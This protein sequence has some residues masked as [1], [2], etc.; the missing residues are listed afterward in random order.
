MHFNK[1]TNIFLNLLMVICFLT[2]WYFFAPGSLGGRVEYVI[3]NGNSMEPDYHRGDLVIIAQ[4]SSYQVGDVVTYRD[5]QIDAYVIHRIIGED[6]GKYILKGDN[7]GWIDNTRPDR[8]QILGKQWLYIPK[9][10]EQIFWLRKPLNMALVTLVLGGGIIFSMVIQSDREKPTLKKKRKRNS[11]AGIL[12]YVLYGLS[13]FVFLFLVLTVFSFTKPVMKKAAPI[14]Y[15]QTGVFS[16]TANGSPTVYDDGQVETGEPVY[17]KSACVVNFQ[18]SYS[19]NGPDLEFITGTN[20]ISAI[21]QNDKTGWKKTLELSPRNS[22]NAVGYVNNASLDLCNLISTIRGIEEETGVRTSIYSVSIQSEIVIDGRMSGVLFRDMYTQNMNFKLDDVQFYLSGNSSDSKPS[23]LAREK[24]IENPEWVENQVN[25]LG[26]EVSVKLIRTIS[27]F[28]MLLSVFSMVVLWL[29]I[30]HISKVDR[31][32]YIRLKYGQMII[33]TA[34]SGWDKSLL[35]VDVVNIDELAKIANRHN[36]MI[37]HTFRDFKHFYL[38][39]NEG[40]VYRYFYAD[41][42]Y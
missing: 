40:T 12:E 8:S 10:G 24:T 22:F 35:I 4:A 28:G 16:Y 34:I 32:G 31:N 17:L 37:M 18:Y 36:T 7:N 21:I 23:F 1:Q 9:A 39:E 42:S 25:V 11:Y 38:V 2:I 29:Y 13:I 14:P 3:V 19:F 30:D 15:Q 33:E 27:I 41:S 6:S 20:A 5:D 26:K